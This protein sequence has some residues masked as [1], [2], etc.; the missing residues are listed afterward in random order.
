M[1]GCRRIG[2]LLGEPLLH[3]RRSLEPVRQGEEVVEEEIVAAVAPENG[4]RLADFPGIEWEQLGRLQPAEEPEVVDGTVG[5][6]GIGLKVGIGEFFRRLGG[7]EAGGVGDHVGKA[8]GRL[9]RQEV[10]VGIQDRLQGGCHAED[11]LLVA[12]G[13]ELEQV[14]IARPEGQFHDRAPEPM[15]SLQV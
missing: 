5:A 7:P 15:G 10:E 13:V 4:R 14:V 8:P 3:R 11:T 1:D 2:L 9:G 12:G 6:E